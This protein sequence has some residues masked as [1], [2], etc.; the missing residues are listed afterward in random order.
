MAFT[1]E[2]L[3]SMSDEELEA[4]FKEAK[5]E[6][7][8]PE[9]HIENEVN[10]TDLPEPEVDSVEE[11]V[12]DL[13]QPDEDEDSDDDTSSTDEDEEDSDEDSETDEDEEDSDEDS[14]T[15]ED[16]LDG[17][18]EEED[19]EPTDEDNE[20]EEEEQPV[21]KFK[22]KANGKE[23]EFSENEIFEKFGQV[24]GQA[25]NYTQK[26]QTIKPW[27]KTIDAIE[28]ADLSAEDINLAI[29]VLK[30]DKD[31]IASLLKRTGV[32]ALELDVDN[33]N[34]TPK[35]YGRND[36]ELAIKDIVEEIKG[37]T[38]Y[39]T[40]YDIL[41]KQW[42]SKSRQE[43]VANPELIR[44]LHIDVKNGMFKTLAPLADK[45]KTYDNGRNSDLDYYKMAA[46]QYYAEQ[47]TT[48]QKQAEKERDIQQKETV[49]KV[50]TATEKRKA[51]KASSAKRKAAAPS[52][53]AAGPSKVTDYLDDSDESYDEWYKKLEASI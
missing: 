32:D 10:D 28:Q 4:A 12:D 38:E 20:S 11:E 33:T 48:Q 47:Q 19:E 26:M 44:D 13:E 25:Q 37:D 22:Y 31:A 1:D 49:E 5:A 53:K 14:E 27:R 30:G 34:Y 16:D 9:T 43:F 42:D 21:R 41:E 46:R 6:E 23:Y 35:D 29:D 24:F 7:T 17:D 51:T 39:V 50:K 3:Y 40:T 45:L 52:K 36:T 8:S 15:D 2:E 18:S